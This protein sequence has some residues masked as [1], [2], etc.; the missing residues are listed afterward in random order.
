MGKTEFHNQI[1]KKERKWSFP[2][3]IPYQLIGSQSH[4][5][6][7]KLQPETEELLG[8][9]LNIETFHR[10]VAR[11]RASTRTHPHDYSVFVE[12]LLLVQLN[13]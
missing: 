1:R 6:T 3:E 8:S 13:F 11:H 4:P 5:E 2:P 7:Q 12:C 10:A 9:L